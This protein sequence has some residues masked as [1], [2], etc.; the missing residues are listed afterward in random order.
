VVVNLLSNGI[1]F[2]H[3]GGITVSTHY[4]HREN[5]D[6]TELRV[7]R[8][9][10]HDTRTTRHDTRHDTRATA[11]ADVRVVTGR[12]GGHG[13]RDEPRGAVAHLRPVLAGVAQDLPGVRGL[14]AGPVD[15]QGPRGPHGRRPGRAQ[16]QGRRLHLPLHHGVRLRHP[17]PT[18]RG[19]HRTRHTTRHARRGTHSPSLLCAAQPSQGEAQGDPGPPIAGAHAQRQRTALAHRTHRTRPPHTPTAHAHR[20]HRAHARPYPGVGSRARR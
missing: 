1:K 7:P 2:T 13:D 9:D 16:P 5:R 12:G 18:R 4:L 15:R 14:G 6:T 20:T 19:T 11:R 17:L 8:H 10:T 3:R